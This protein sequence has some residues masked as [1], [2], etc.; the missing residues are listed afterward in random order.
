MK[1]GAMGFRC[2]GALVSLVILLPETRSFALSLAL[3]SQG[4]RTPLRANWAGAGAAPGLVGGS[5]RV[6]Y[7]VQG[8]RPCDHSCFGRVGYNR[9]GLG[10]RGDRWER[11]TVMMATSK[12]EKEEALLKGMNPSNTG[13]YPVCAMEDDPS[14]EEVMTIAAAADER[15]ADGVT[16]IRVGARKHKRWVKLVLSD[17][18]KRDRVGF[19]LSHTP[20]KGGAR[21][22]VDD[23]YDWVHVDEMWFYVM[24]DGRVIYLH[25]EEDTPKPP[26]AQ[27]KRFITKVMVLAAVARP[28]MIFN[29][30]WF[31]GKIRIWPIAGTVA[32][33]HRSMNHKKGTMMLKLATINAERYKEL[34]IDKVVPAIKARIPRPSGHTIFVQQDGAK[35][36]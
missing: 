16:A 18:Q 28:R 32:A 29:G 24:K 14:L 12:N 33:M 21:V 22:V 7:G 9:Q 27:N 4:G 26:R 36:H 2:V 6:G 19:A 17:K 10:L 8:A 34:M 23:M 30:V 11:L 31:D 35:P 5:D 13:E 15:K 20:R 3:C 25:P 1:R